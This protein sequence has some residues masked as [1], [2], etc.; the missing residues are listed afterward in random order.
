MIIKR[1]T[2]SESDKKKKKKFDIDPN[3]ELGLSTIMSTGSLA[4]LVSGAGIAGLK[5]KR[6][7]TKIKKKAVKDYKEALKKEEAE[8]KKGLDK[9]KKV[10]GKNKDSERFKSVE[11]DLKKMKKKITQAKKTEIK[12]IRDTA[13]KAA[14]KKKFGRLLKGGMG[15][16]LVGGALSAY[17]A[18][19]YYKKR[20]EGKPKR[21]MKTY[22]AMA[23]GA[24]GG[25]LVNK[26][27]GKS[28]GDTVIKDLKKIGAKTEKEAT[29]KLNK[30]M[31][32][33]LARHFGSMAIGAGVGYTAKK[34]YDKNKKN[35]D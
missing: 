10:A 13:L 18:Y 28:K 20:N 35:K 33:D 3:G 16:T 27:I 4:G 17:P 19:K 21:E 6:V 8:Y 9:L 1:V 7:D 11:N 34:L 14:K 22:E 12:S 26:M 5:N 30:A 29:K 25:S 23:L 15:G 32:K 31:R 2:F 24:T